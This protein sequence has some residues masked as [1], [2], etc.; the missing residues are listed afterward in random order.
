MSQKEDYY[1]LLGVSK[2]CTESELKKAY[3]KQSKKYHP[4][5]NPND[6]ES[7]S[8]FK[9]ISEAYEVLSD[10]NKRAEYDRFG[11]STPG[12]QYGG[13]AAGFGGGFGGFDFGDIG[14]IFEG[15]FGGGG[16][17]RGRSSNPNAPR[18]GEDIYKNISITF[19]EACKGVAKDMTVTYQKTCSSCNGNG[20]KNGTSHSQCGSCNGTGS[21]KVQQRTAF[22]TI[23]TST[24]CSNCKGKGKV[25]TESCTS[26]RGEG[27]KFE[28]EVV[29]VNIPGG[30]DN[31]QTLSIRNAGHCGINGGPRGDLNVTVAVEPDSIF[32]RKGFDIWCEI[33]ITYTQAVLGDEIVVP[34]IDGKVK[35]SIGESTQPGTVFRLRSKGVTHI[36]A[37][38]RGDQ[39]VQVNVEVPKQ[40][41]K[42]Q[43]ES[44]RMFENSLTDKN[45]EKRRGFIDK[46]KDMF[47]D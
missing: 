21:V 9:E 4:D 33:P 28:K 15:F 6:K 24:T 32:S 8:K 10:Q 17:F 26:C 18:Q 7:E 29:S 1:K 27:L 3:R 25:V 31:G 2:D 36:N 19:L 47:K 40:L 37:R 20:S 22:G 12:G 43:R 38:T 11:H 34:T 45:Y 42:S 46:I 23:S 39:Y 30:I 41:S 14:D 13:G 35:Y 5:L 44:L 16:G